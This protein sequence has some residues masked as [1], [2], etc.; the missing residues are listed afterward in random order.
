MTELAALGLSADSKGVVKATGDLD[1]F[2]VA[3]ERA[4]MATDS[5]AGGAKKADA[6][7][8]SEGDA[9]RK[10][11]SDNKR[12][13]DETKTTAGSLHRMASMAGA[14]AGSLI[15][16]AGAALSIGAYTRL[17]D[18][19]SDMRSQLGAAT[20]DMGAAGS[21]MQRMVDI[22][23]ASYS[24][25][26]QTVEVYARNVGVLRELGINAAKAA[27]F[28][29]SLNH[30]LVITA[31]KGERAASV[32][33]ALSKAMAVGKLQ[34]DGLETVLANGGRV[35]EA[36]AVQ[37]GTTVSG[38]RDLAS[39][40]KIT[41]NV[42]A[43][44]I[45]N[46]LEEVRAVAGEM[47][48][49]IGDAF[50][51]I[52]TNV[53]TLIGRFD[54]TF[55]ISESVASSLIGVADRI[56]EISQ[57]DF[58]A[59]FSSLADAAMGAGVIILGL[60]ATQIPALILSLASSVTLLSATEALFIA[61]SV[62]SRGMAV[63]VGILSGSVGALNT[64]MSFLG[65]PLG[66]AVGAAIATIGGAYLLLSKK[67][68][69][70]DDFVADLNG[71]LSKVPGYGEGANSGARVAASGFKVAGDAASTAEGQINSMLSAYGKFVAL[72]PSAG[73]MT[74]G[75][76][77]GAAEIEAFLGG[78][79]MPL[80]EAGADDIRPNRAPNGIGGVDWGTPPSTRSSGGGGGGGGGS[81]Q[82]A[83]NLQNLVESLATE[84]AT[85]DAWYESSM[86]ILNDRRAQEILG[87]ET[88]NATKEALEKEHADRIRNIEMAQ[89]D[90]RLG[91][92][93][94]FFGAMAGLVAAGG[95][96]MAKA[97][98]TFGAVEATINAYRAAAQAAADPTVPFWG[99]AA[100][101]AS[102][103]GTVIQSVRA[104]KQAGGGGGGGSAGA[105]SGGAQSASR[106]STQEGPMRVSADAFDPSKLYTG[107]AV[108]KW[109]NAMQG[110]AKNRGIEWVPS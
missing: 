43:Q 5:L 24:P 32:Q 18:S 103:F 55:S 58:A 44:A 99:K 26:D 102:A 47:P 28:T 101:Y 14:V 68:E 52:G 107:E 56:A 108:Q 89:Q 60:A 48:A 61:G 57:V 104:I 12:L 67:A 106:T 19:W 100:A 25:L 11:A 69:K 7:V 50:G 70:A 27:D 87:L 77:G 39:E 46:P 110:E 54:Q 74:G 80:R 88:F 6:A 2:S 85:T 34:A 1:K 105:A 63:S 72:D 9:A 16:M 83:S 23:N 8:K 65:G 84:R 92:T 38:L 76:G 86:S 97:A 64:V 98:A 94:S 41:G 42:I 109:F 71:T 79:G 66:I 3:A 31:T 53:Q 82:Y 20:G 22:A 81:D 36:L 91:Y 21:M 78:V 17:A 95:G 15:A 51:R 37:L 4:D 29:E 40:G 33:D 13:G 49:T 90:E 96:K 35:A 93:S 73:R 45:I 59:W 10:A 75:G 30:M 62:A